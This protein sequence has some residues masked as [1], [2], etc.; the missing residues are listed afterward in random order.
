MKYK[1]EIKDQLLK[2]CEQEIERTIKSIHEVL[3]SVEESRNNET[4]S[5]VGDKYETGRT[6]MQMEEEKNKTQLFR[7]FQVKQELANIDPGRIHNKVE[8]G[9]LVETNKGNYYISIGIGKVR[10]DAGLYYCVST[11]SPIGMKMMGKAIGDEIEF[12]GVKMLIKGLC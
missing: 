6:M 10:L 12:N 4:K 3:K 2:T 8:I 11:G 9:S 5:S 1:Y 7:A